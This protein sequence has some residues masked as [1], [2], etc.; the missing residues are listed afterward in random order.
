[1]SAACRPR[2]RH[3]S[4]KDMWRDAT[5]RRWRICARPARSFSARPTCTSSRSAPP[6]RTRRSVRRATPAIR[7]GRP[8]GRAADR[9][10]AS[11][12]A[13]RS[14]RLAP[15]RAARSAWRSRRIVRVARRSERRILVGRA[16]R[17]LV[18]VGLAQEDRTGLAKM[19]DRRAVARGDMPV[20]DAR[21][22]RRRDAAHVEQV[23]DRDRDAVQRAAIAAGG[24]LTVGV[25]RLTARFVGRHADERVQPAVVG[26]DPLQTLVG[27]LRRRHFTRAHPPAE[28]FD[29]HHH[30]YVGARRS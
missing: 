10:R 14:R 21:R 12:P 3:A 23:L 22:R 1:M 11:P 5:R 16:E 17:E 4:A 27:D 2:R 28:F 6:T 19:R 26:L 7:P 24:D 20:A 8:A 29:G 18:Q 13:W 15:I 9:G 25:L 30:A